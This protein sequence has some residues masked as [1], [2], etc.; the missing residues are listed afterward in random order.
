MS[1]DATFQ[2]GIATCTAC[3]SSKLQ[4]KGFFKVADDRLLKDG[5]VQQL[6]CQ[7]H[8]QCKDCGERQIVFTFCEEDADGVPW[9]RLSHTNDDWEG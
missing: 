1:I 7:L 4:F 2:D 9:V 3:R 6:A 5:P 8:L